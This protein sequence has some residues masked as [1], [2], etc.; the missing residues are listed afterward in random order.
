[1]MPPSEDTTE[2]HL[3]ATMHCVNF[4]LIN[5]ALMTTGKWQFG[6]HFNLVNLLASLVSAIY[7]RTKKDIDGALSF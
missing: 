2:K 7:F 4:K 3:R 1:M 6:G 5:D